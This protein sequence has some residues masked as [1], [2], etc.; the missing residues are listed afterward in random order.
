MKNMKGF[1]IDGPKQIADM[2]PAVTSPAEPIT[3]R[4]ADS[5]EQEISALVKEKQ[6]RISCMAKKIKK[7]QS[8]TGGI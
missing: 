5:R 8:S 7:S 1:W 6:P 3:Q 2:A 4:I